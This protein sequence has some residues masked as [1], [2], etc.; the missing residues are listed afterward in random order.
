MEYAFFESHAAAKYANQHLCIKLRCTRHRAAT[1]KCTAF[2]KDTTPTAEHAHGTYSDLPPAGKN[3]QPQQTAKHRRRSGLPQWWTL[4]D[5][6]R[7]SL[8]EQLRDERTG[9][10]FD[11]GC[12]QGIVHTEI[13]AP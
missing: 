1:Y 13:I 5:S 9:R 12:K 7:L 8:R 11:Y 10:T 6:C 4:R 2:P 3:H